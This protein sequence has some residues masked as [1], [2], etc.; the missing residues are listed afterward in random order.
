[1]FETKLIKKRGQQTRRA[2]KFDESFC[3]RF[4]VWLNIQQVFALT[5]GKYIT[6]EMNYGNLLRDIGSSA[7]AKNGKVNNLNLYV[8]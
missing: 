7:F 8:Y 1:M 2:L 5:P 3:V 6:T 4:P